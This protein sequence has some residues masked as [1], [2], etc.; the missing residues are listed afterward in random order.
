MKITRLK[1]GSLACCLIIVM[2]ISGTLLWFGGLLAREPIGNFVALQGYQQSQCTILSKD[3]RYYSSFNQD[4]GNNETQYG[5]NFTFQMHNNASSQGYG[6]DQ[7]TFDQREDAQNI[8]DQYTVGKSYPCWYNPADAAHAV[9]T[10]D[11]TTWI[12]LLPGGIMLIIGVGLLIGFVLMVRW[13]WRET[14]FLVTR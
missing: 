7:H 4:T 9:L 1:W 12:L 10:R 11:I 3:L 2:A 14:A 8:L 6:I 5:P 13:L